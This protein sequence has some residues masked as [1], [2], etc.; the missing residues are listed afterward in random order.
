VSILGTASSSFLL[1]HISRTFLRARI[2]LDK[3]STDDAI[4]FA[5]S[6]AKLSSTADEKLKAMD[7]LDR[8]MAVRIAARRRAD[9]LEQAAA[10]ERKRAAEQRRRV[11]E[12]LNAFEGMEAHEVSLPLHAY[13]PRLSSSPEQILGVS[14]TASISV[15]RSAYRKL[16]MKRGCVFSFAVNTS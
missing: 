6:A 12:I 16:A 9:E 13:T 2:L 14:E 11:Q 7:L 1:P 15:V 10:A 3:E 8:A 4:Y 5:K